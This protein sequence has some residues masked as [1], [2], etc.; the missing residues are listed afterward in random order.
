[1]YEFDFRLVASLSNRLYLANGNQQ[2]CEEFMRLLLSEM[3]TDQGDLIEPLFYGAEKTL[4]LFE[5]TEDGSCP[6]C[7]KFNREVEEEFLMLK[8]PLPDSSA[9]IPLSNLIKR[10]SEREENVEKKCENCCTHAA[11][12]PQSGACKSHLVVRQT[13]LT[14]IGK[15]LIIQLKRYSQG[16]K[17]KTKVL[18]EEVLELNN[19]KYT[20]SSVIEHSGRTINA[21]HYTCIVRDKNTFR[22]CNDTISKEVDPSKLFRGNSDLYMFIYKKVPVDSEQTKDFAETEEFVEPN[23]FVETAEFV[24]A[25]D[26]VPTTE[27]ASTDWWQNT[28]KFWENTEWT[29]NTMS[30]GNDTFENDSEEEVPV[31][32]TET[33][34]G[35]NESRASEEPVH[36]VQN[37]I[38]P[39][40]E[41][42]EV[43]TPPDLSAHRTVPDTVIE[44]RYEIL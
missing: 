25:D 24:Q 9:E 4:H 6:T 1:M 14:R 26:S 29:K 41:D 37:E 15:F 27:A 40:R 19:Q 8:L 30:Q 17:N 33:R 16:N 7:K 2:D 38:H 11:N 3:R 36:K 28:R 42:V 31:S 22:H 13:K 35:E 39:S 20:L 10:Y 5:N 21:G 23:E 34:I 12:C 32:Q 44:G 18:P 43:S